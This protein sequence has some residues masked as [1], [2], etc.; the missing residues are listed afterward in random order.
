M[1][2]YNNQSFLQTSI[3][4]ILNQT[5]KDIELIV[6]DDCSTDYSRDLLDYYADRD[7]RFR[8]FVMER[9][10]GAAA[11]RNFGNNKAASSIIMVMDSGDM[12]HEE[13]AKATFDFFQ[14]NEDID[15][16]SSACVEVD[17]C[18]NQ[19]E[20]HEPKPFNDS[21]KPSLFHPTVAYRKAVTDTIKYREGNLYTDQYEVFFLEAFKAGFN[22]GFTNDFWVKKLHQSKI[23]E[24]LDERYRQ[25]VKN[26]QEF[27][28]EI[29]AFLKQYVE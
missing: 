22:F 1:P 8:Y 15:I 2:N 13:R 18:D 21:E 10:L 17:A 29:P 14:K 5:V 24:E 6:V 27:D 9:R 20:L 26:Y 3:D 4:S 25:R 23:P 19:L 11:C 28:I 16:Y 7:N 12:S